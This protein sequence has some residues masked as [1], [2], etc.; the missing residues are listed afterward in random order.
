VVPDHH[1]GP[2]AADAGEFRDLRV[3]LI[4]ARLAPDSME[5]HVLDALVELG[6]KTRYVGTA[7][8]FDSIGAVGNAALAKATRFLWR[9]PERLVE[10]RL[11]DQAG[12]FQPDV[13]LVLQGNHLSPK[14]VA[15]LRRASAAPIVCWCQDH[16]GTLGRQ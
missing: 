5:S 3:M 7:F 2:G 15:G 10:R 16:V 13:L 1:P 4:G 14:T 9:E 11:I 12:E 8:W 6:C